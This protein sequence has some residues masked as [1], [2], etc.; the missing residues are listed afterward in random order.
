MASQPVARANSFTDGFRRRWAAISTTVVGDIV[1]TTLAI[2]G[3]CFLFIACTFA[4]LGLLHAAEFAL[5]HMG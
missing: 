3:M 2:G 4:I 5:R 1:G